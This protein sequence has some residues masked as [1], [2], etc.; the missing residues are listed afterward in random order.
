M[1]VQMARRM[2]ASAP[3]DDGLDKASTTRPSSTANFFV[4]SLDKSSAYSSS[5]NFTINKNQ[6][7]FNGF[8]HRIAVNEVVMDWGVPNIAQWWGNNF[9]TV[10]VDDGNINGTDYTVTLPD[11]FYSALDALDAIVTALNAAPGQT[12]TF[13]VGTSGN[14]VGLG[15][16]QSFLV[17]WEQSATD[18][19]V[20]AGS[21]PNYDP[22]NALARALFSSSQLYTGALPVLTTNAL[23]SPAIY[24]VSPLILGTRYVDFVSPQ[25]T[26]NQD[27]KDNTTAQ[28]TRDVIYRWYF[29]WDTNSGTDILTGSPTLYPYYII[30]GY[31][32]FNQRRFLPY[33]KQILWDPT[34]PIGQVSFEVY[35]DR[36][37]LLDTTKFTPSA[38]FQFQMSMLLSEN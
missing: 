30:Q 4:D 21:K 38:N 23:F 11:G 29:A 5:T 27:L 20:P 8:F 34:M 33:P 32:P 35:D 2:G 28:I 6:A 19:T 24:S 25:L 16:T 18:A 12:A 22:N 13:S 10:S 9:L 3:I 37:R 26:Y 36:G 14:R 15:A 7:L 1:A 31:K 17:V